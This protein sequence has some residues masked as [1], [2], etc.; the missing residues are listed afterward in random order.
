MN[1]GF[2]P[3]ALGK[4][5]IKDELQHNLMEPEERHNDIAA[6][7]INRYLW[8]LEQESYPYSFVPV[9]VPPGHGQCVPECRYC[10]VD[11]RME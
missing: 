8:N 6:L 7:R 11:E 2:C 3:D 9:M 1:F 10:G 4:Y 5:I